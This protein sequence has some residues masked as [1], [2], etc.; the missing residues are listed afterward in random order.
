MNRLLTLM[1]LFAGVLVSVNKTEAGSDKGAPS[2]DHETMSSAAQPPENSPWDPRLGNSQTDGAGTE[3]EP[4]QPS[5][6]EE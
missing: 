2:S 6:T 3:D 1:V 4:G 5:Q